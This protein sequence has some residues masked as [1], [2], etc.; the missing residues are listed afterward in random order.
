MKPI[1]ILLLFCLSANWV[2]AQKDFQDGFVITTKNDTLEGKVS[3]VHKNSHNYIDFLYPNGTDTIFTPN[4]ISSYEIG[5][6]RFEVVPVPHPTRSDTTYLFAKVL[7]EG[8]ANLYKTKIKTDFITSAEDA[9]LCRKY[10]ENNYYPAGKMSS[11]AKFFSDNP[12]LASELK[13]NAHVYSNNI[14]TK[15][16]LFNNYNTW[17]KHQLD[18]LSAIDQNQSLVPSSRT[19]VE[20]FMTDTLEL[21]A[22]SKIELDKIASRLDK[23]PSLSMVC[24]FVQIS[25]D[26]KQVKRVMKAVMRHLSQLDARIEEKIVSVS[27]NQVTLPSKEGAQVLYYH[28]K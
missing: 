21:T 3:N 26:E 28:F 14:D 24:E 8:Y 6:Q 27:E 25:P 20:M 5:N 15:I 17:K 4:H 23:D 2:Q 7:V 22:Y 16:H 19:R 13:S 10:N 11:L 18:S 12:V 1:L 9:Y